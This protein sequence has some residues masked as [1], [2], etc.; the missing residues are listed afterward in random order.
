[1]PLL[2]HFRPPLSRRRHWASLH[3]FWAAAAARWLNADHLPPRYFAEMRLHSGSN[4]ESDTP[5]LPVPAA[6][7]P[8]LFP[9]KLEVLVFNDEGGPTRV[10][11]LEFVSPGNKDRDAARQ[12][13]LVKCASYLQQGIGLVMVDVVTTRL[14]NLH[15]ELMRFLGANG[16]E[17]LADDVLLYTA[18]Y[19][20]VRRKDDDQIDVWPTP[21]ALGQAL[22]T[23]PLALLGYGCVPL[24][25]EASYTE[26]RQRL[27]LD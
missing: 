13:F 16:A 1:M 21:L 2:D 3:G 18:A 8:A 22:P 6:V 11:A 15:N 7:I 14:A 17:A 4:V 27:V 5:T 9:D 25:L 24:D 26:A 23:M 20:P 12:A 10:A 19:R